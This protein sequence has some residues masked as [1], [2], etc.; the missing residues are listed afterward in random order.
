[1]QAEDAGRLSL[2]QHQAVGVPGQVQ[3]DPLLP[4][5]QEAG[6]A[7][8]GL[9]DEFEHLV[10]WDHLGIWT[11]AEDQFDRQPREVGRLGVDDGLDPGEGG[12]GRHRLERVVAGL[13]GRIYAEVGPGVVLLDGEQADPLKQPD[14]PGLTDDEIAHGRERITKGQPRRFY[15]TRAPYEARRSCHCTVRS[16]R[17]RSP[18]KC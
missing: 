3:V 14:D 4:A 7:L 16:A 12:I 5:V 13:D 6:H 10:L 17:Q 9:G 11:R 18:C 8:R 15:P 1:M 2:A